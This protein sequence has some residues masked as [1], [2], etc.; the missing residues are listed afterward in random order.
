MGRENIP[1]TKL[2][3]EIR[4]ILTDMRDGQLPSPAAI[5]W[6]GNE[7]HGW[8]VTSAPIPEAELAPATTTNARIEGDDA[9]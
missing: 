1:V 3:E 2:L 8:P 4:D 6:A 7:L 9:Q 5:E